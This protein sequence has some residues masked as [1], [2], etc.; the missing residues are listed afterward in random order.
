ME[1]SSCGPGLDTHAET[2]RK[3]KKRIKHFMLLYTL[4]D[5]S[6]GF[7]ILVPFLRGPGLL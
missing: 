5:V 1:K 7:Q 2:K 6:A 3:E 4:L